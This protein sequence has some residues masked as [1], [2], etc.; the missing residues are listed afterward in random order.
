MVS[1]RAAGIHRMMS[2]HNL[3]RRYTVVAVALAIGAIFVY[4]GLD[5]I[6]DLLQFADSI[7]A[8]AIPIRIG[9]PRS[10]GSSLCYSLS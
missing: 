10:A 6:R 2:R 4:A 1:Y 9:A 7:Y 8:F 3:L 5:K